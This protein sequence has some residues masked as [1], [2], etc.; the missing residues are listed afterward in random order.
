[1]A[2]LLLCGDGK[3]NGLIGMLIKNHPVLLPLLETHLSDLKQ[4]TP[5]SIHAHTYQRGEL[6]FMFQA[7]YLF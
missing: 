4:S 2:L 1:V 6:Y 5:L 7:K 3:L